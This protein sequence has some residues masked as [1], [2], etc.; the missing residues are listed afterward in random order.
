MCV[1]LIRRLYFS[2]SEPVVADWKVKYCVHLTHTT[3]LK[4]KSGQDSF[5]DEASQET[6]ERPPKK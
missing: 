6:A 1:F 4:C 3:P 5:P 2:E